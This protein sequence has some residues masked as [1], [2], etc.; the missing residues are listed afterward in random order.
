MTEY[1]EVFVSGKTKLPLK[2]GKVKLDRDWGQLNDWKIIINGVDIMTDQK[3]DRYERDHPMLRA[4]KQPLIEAA[5]AE[6]AAL[7]QA[8]QQQID[9]DLYGDQVQYH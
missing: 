6:R 3:W 9:Q 7:A 8:N 2:F 1:T 4:A 5:E